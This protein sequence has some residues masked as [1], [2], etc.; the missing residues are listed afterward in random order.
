MT[1]A[2]VDGAHIRTLLL[3]FFFRQMQQLFLNDMIYIAQPPLYEIKLKG[4]KKS[5]YILSE[6]Q[7]HKR[8]IT[9]GLD[10]T[11]LVIT[12][13]KKTRK[14]KKAASKRAS[15]PPRKLQDKELLALVKLLA[16][17]ERIIAVLSRRGI[18]FT[19]FLNN[20]ARS[21]KIF[22]KGSD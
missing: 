1:D 17:A 9:R 13:N 5:E 22:C 21:P 8:M 11:K 6:N 19:K 4:K 7:M 20:L 16:E 18:K 2:D 10:G 3:T 14:S 15:S 12:D